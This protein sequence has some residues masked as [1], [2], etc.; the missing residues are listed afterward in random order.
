LFFLGDLPAEYN[1]AE[2]WLLKAA[3]KG[4]SNAMKYLCVIYRDGGPNLKKDRSAY[5]KWLKKL[6]EVDQSSCNL[7]KE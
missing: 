6:C 2:S 1:E 5:K 7:F 4:V 3:E